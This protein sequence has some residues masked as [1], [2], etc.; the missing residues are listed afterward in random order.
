LRRIALSLAVVTTLACGG[1]RPPTLP[2]LFPLSTVWTVQVG[3]G[4]EGDLASDGPRVYL[5]T[6]EGTVR[7]FEQG[8]GREA[9]RAEATSRRSLS[10]RPGAVVVRDLE[11]TASAL[12]PRDGR[13]LWTAATGVKGDLGPAFSDDLVYVAG[14][15]LVAL[16]LSTG[17]LAWSASDGRPV[18]APPVVIGSCLL[19]GESDGVLRCRDPRSGASRWTLRTG[20]ALL[21]PPAADRDG[22]LVL[23]TTDRRILSID[24]LKGK[25]RWQWKVGADVERPAAASGNRVFVAAFDAVLYALDAGNGNLAWRTPLPSRPLS[26][27]MVIRGMILVACH[28]NEILGFEPRTGKRVGGLKTRELLRTAPLLRGDR[29]FVALRD[30]SLEA[31]DLPGAILT[32]EDDAEDRDRTSE[33]P[34]KP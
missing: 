14:E 10:A 33:T 15:G 25:E 21:A 22:H 5:T 17:Q 20:S 9:W 23:G 18:S 28:E 2:A 24:A 16:Q 29:L 32:P 31:M 26:G 7:A 3:T 6:R 12:D 13:T 1:K 30:R 4:M 34:A 11:G 19:V 27:P 8:T